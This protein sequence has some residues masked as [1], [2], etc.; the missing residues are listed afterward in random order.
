MYKPHTIRDQITFDPDLTFIRKAAFLVIDRVQGM[1]PG[2]QLMGS[3]VAVVAMAEALGL[4]PHD[5]ITRSQNAMG[6]VEGPF[7]HQVQAIRD[8]ARNELGRG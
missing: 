1:D 2:D 3:A 8:Y 7:T 4:D 5:L 6:A